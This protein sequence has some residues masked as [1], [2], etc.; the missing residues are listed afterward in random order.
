MT[1]AHFTASV[2]ISAAISADVLGRGSNPTVAKRSR[3]SGERS[4]AVISAFRRW[5][6]GAGVAAGARMPN[7][8]AAS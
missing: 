2:F 4:T 1:R 7:Q 3:T 8:P 6:T 5:T